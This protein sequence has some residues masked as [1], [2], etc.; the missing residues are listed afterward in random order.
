MT[1]S[2]ELVVHQKGENSLQVIGIGVVFGGLGLFFF[3]MDPGTIERYLDLPVMFVRG[4]GLVATV[5][6][7][8]LGL[9]AVHT[10]FARSPVLV[11]N[12][13]GVI[14]RTGSLL[15]LRSKGRF[16]PWDEI[17][18]IRT[19]ESYGLTA[20]YLYLRSENGQEGRVDEHP[21]PSTAAKPSKNV[22]EIPVDALGATEGELERAIRSYMDR[23]GR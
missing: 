13:D 2:D 1:D 5:F 21:A 6:F 8:L 14:N 10:H 18:D 12:R 23:H 19:G 20:V 16:I 22:V 7:G 15:R 17:E 9:L 3:L 4:F 11:I